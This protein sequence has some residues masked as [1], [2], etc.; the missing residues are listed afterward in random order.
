MV[1]CQCGFITICN[2]CTT[3]VGDTD[4]GEG[5]ACLGAG[6]YVCS[7]CYRPLIF[8]VDLKLL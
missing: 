8:A 3:L 4:N 1:M 6:G 7:Q 2:K 5:N